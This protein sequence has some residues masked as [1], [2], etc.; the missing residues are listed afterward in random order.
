M[1]LYDKQYKPTQQQPVTKAA[2]EPRRPLDTLGDLFP[3]EIKV[4]KVKKGKL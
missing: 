3:K 1:T 4:K 2:Q